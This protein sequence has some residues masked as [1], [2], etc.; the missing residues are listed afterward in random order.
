MRYTITQFRKDYPNE[1]ACLEK[2]FQLRYAS[3]G[4]CPGCGIVNPNFQKVENRR[5]YQCMDCYQQFYPTAGTVFEKTRTPLTLWFYAM[6]LMI[7]TRNGVAAKELERA[8][9]ISYKCAWRMARQI[10][11]LMSQDQIGKLFGQVQ[12]DEMYYGGKMKKHG[13]N[14]RDKTPVFAMVE[15]KGRVIAMP[16]VDVKRASV[17]PEIEK[18]VEKGSTVYTDEYVIYQ[19][20]AD[21]VYVHDTVKHLM[22]EYSRDGV[23]TNA[24]EGFFMHLQRMIKGSH[25]WVSRKH[26]KLYINECVYR[27]NHR[28]TGG[29][30]FDTMLSFLKPR[31]DDGP[32]EMPQQLYEVPPQNPA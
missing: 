4:A 32:S 9:G 26:L 18:N 5:C 24:V 30:M 3:L 25:I 21:M 17:F 28:S 13:R 19:N 7:V 8:L 12:A 15:N 22:G 16:M 23:T 6:Y 27:Y 14:N 10:R 11:L 31:L 2:L 29:Q 1:E 20:L